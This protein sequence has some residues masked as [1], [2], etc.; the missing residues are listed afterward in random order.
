M[1]ARR[2]GTGS[3]SGS[4]QSAAGTPTAADCC[5]GGTPVVIPDTAAPMIIAASRFRESA[6]TLIR[7]TTSGGRRRSVVPAALAV[8]MATS[9]IENSVRSHIATC[10][11]HIATV[12]M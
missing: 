12:A 9:R 10:Q 5:T 7:L 2:Q 1:V 3:C 4:I 6:G 11:S 8:G